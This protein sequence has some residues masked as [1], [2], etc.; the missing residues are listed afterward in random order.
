MSSRSVRLIASTTTSASVTTHT[1]KVGSKEDPHQYSPHSITADVGDVVEFQFY[2]RNHSVVKA[3]Y[4]APC[5]PAS[6]NIFYSGSF[7]NF[8][9]QNGQL[10]GPPPSWYLVVNDT[11]PTF[12]Y[13][14]AIDSCMKNG[15][16]GV[17]NPNETMTWEAQ[18]A[19]AKQY[20]YMLVPGQSMPA[21]GDLPSTTSTSRPTTSTAH[22]HSSTSSGTHLSGG[23]IAGIVIGAVAFLVILVAL[24][25]TLGRNRVYKEWMSSQDGRTERTARWALFHGDGWRPKSELDS[26]TQHTGDQGTSL[27]SSPI[28]TQRTFSPPPPAGHWSWEAPKPG[29][30]SMR[31]PTELD[32][33]NSMHGGVYR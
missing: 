18:Y 32:A 19:K 27:V 6:G 2:P 20:P 3:D 14:T 26:T 12:F 24:L 33:S 30:G 25:F 17:I 23:A 5:V 1:V 31:E 7:N 11:Q 9:E 16:V 29:A 13:C 4:L 10:I 21:E 22:P 15:M 8:N 28:P